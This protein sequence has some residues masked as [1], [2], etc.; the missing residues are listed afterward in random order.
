LTLICFITP[1][2][3]S[4]E[5][6]TVIYE[7]VL[8]TKHPEFKGGEEEMMKY[9]Q[10]NIKY[11]TELANHSDNSRIFI[12]FTV[13]KNG[14]LSDFEVLRSITKEVDDA[15]I[16]FFKSMPDWNPGEIDGV[17]VRSKMI[18]PIQIDLN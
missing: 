10:K 8:L 2:S 4:Q 3:W 7:S 11:P 12:Q 17:P 18:I 16:K 9:M 13:N 6:D 5:V 1:K 15:F 14:K